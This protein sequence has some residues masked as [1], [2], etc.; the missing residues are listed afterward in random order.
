M[1]LD[2]SEVQRRYGMGATIPT[3]A[4]GKTL[5]ITS[6]DDNKIY[7]RHRLWT[8]ALCREHLEEGRRVDRRGQDNEARR[9]VRRGLPGRGGRRPCDLRGPRAQA[10][11][12]PRLSPP[13]T[14]AQSSDAVR[15][16]RDRLDTAG[17]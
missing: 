1:P 14:H 17:A 4:G 9:S 7:I 15:A 8:D 6:V 10:P 11:R 5:E 3:V 13:G 16:E 2:W 12:I